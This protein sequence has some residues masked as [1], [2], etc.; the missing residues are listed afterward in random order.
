MARYF[1]H[2]H[3]NGNLIKDH[4]GSEFANL[5]QVRVEAM[6]T[7]PE[8]AKDQVP[9]DGNRQAYMVL[10]TDEAGGPVYSATLTFAGLW[11][12]SDAAE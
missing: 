3:Q 11:L 10:V 5:E 1:F 12:N 2:I 8:I 6:H 7:L 4:E 9:K